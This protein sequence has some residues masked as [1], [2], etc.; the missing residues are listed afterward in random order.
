M[1]KHDTSV[2]Y[3]A[4]PRPAA[5]TLIEVLVV[6]SIIALLVAILLPSL[7]RARR[8]ARWT[9]CLNNLHQISVALYSYQ[10]D[11]K[12]V[13]KWQLY[14]EQRADGLA[15]WVQGLRGFGHPTRL[16]MLYPRYVGK[17]ENVFY[18]PDAATNGLLNKGTENKTARSL[19]PWSNWGTDLGWA[20]GSYEYRPRYYFPASG[21]PVWVGANYDTAKNAR[22]SIAG[23]GFAGAWDAFGP[24]PAHSPI[25]EAPKML[26]YNVAYMDG[27]A[28][29]SKDHLKTSAGGGG[30][31]FA[32][33]AGPPSQQKPFYV[34]AAREGG[35]GTTRLPPEYTP[36]RPGPEN[37]PLPTDRQ[38]REQILASTNHIDRGWTFFDRR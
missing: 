36:L 26:Y 27:S 13:P 28:R 30:Q 16:G 32:T 8:Q 18:C 6:V 4:R 21:K 11:F 3:K 1:K 31:E 7:Q 37:E 15:L 20:Y 19:Y 38:K 9:A 34:N 22:L 23:D 5:F 14:D 33:R 12:T 35:V 10:A 24:F 2:R 29:P 25:R 17:N